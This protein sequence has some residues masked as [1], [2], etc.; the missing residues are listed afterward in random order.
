MVVWQSQPD[1]MSPSCVLRYALRVTQRTVWNLIWVASDKSFKIWFG[2]D[3]KPPTVWLLRVSCHT[4]LIKAIWFQSGYA[5]NLIQAASLNV[6]LV[7]VFSISPVLP[8][9]LPCISVFTLF[10][11][12]L[13]PDSVR[14]VGATL[15]LLFIGL[16]NVQ[17]LLSNSTPYRHC[18][19]PWTSRYCSSQSFPLL[20][21]LNH[22][23]SAA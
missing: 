11:L 13:S 7:P 3:F 17:A 4:L 19:T 9:Y 22:K 8:F 23:R 21:F 20:N 16:V 5:Q 18:A 6:T 14:L 10:S 2:S 12:F 15:K 1:V